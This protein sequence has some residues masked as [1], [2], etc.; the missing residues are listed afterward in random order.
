MVNERATTE[1]RRTASVTP[2]R[3][4]AASIVQ[5]MQEKK[6]DQ[7]VVMDMRQVSGLADYFVLCS[8]ESDLQAKALIEHIRKTVKERFRELPWNV[9]GE[10]YLQWVL[11][12]Y[13]DVVA[14]I[15]TPEKRSF[16][17]LERLWGDAPMERVA[18]DQERVEL[19]TAMESSDETPH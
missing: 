9:E 7:I 19:L 2:S 1:K 4:L 5:A 11:M 17:E 8:A 18:E 10:D 15:L 14:H 3:E 13:V 16:Y 6:G 12:D